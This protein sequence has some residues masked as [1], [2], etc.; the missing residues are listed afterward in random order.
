MNGFFAQYQPWGG[1]E[2]GGQSPEAGTSV[3]DETTQQRHLLGAG[4]ST[5]IQ[6]YKPYKK[7]REMGRQ[8]LASALSCPPVSSRASHRSNLLG[9]WKGREPANRVLRDTKQIQGRAGSPESNGESR[10]QG[11]K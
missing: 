10:L 7:Q 6:P 11:C 3:E 9:K 8:T 4:A 2:E 5:E 1:G